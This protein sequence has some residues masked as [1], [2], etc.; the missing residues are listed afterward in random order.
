MKKLLSIV[1]TLALM[2]SL[3]ACLGGCKKEQKPLRILLDYQSWGDDDTYQMNWDF[4]AFRRELIEAGGPADIELEIVPKVSNGSNAERESKLTRIRTE[5]MAGQGPD[6]F[7]MGYQSDW[8]SNNRSLFLMPEKS[9]ELGLFYP[10]DGFLENAQYMHYDEMIPEIVSAGRSEEYGQVVLP[11]EYTFRTT[12]FM[13]DDVPEPLEPCTWQEQA[14]S[15]LT[16]YKAAATQLSAYSYMQFTGSLGKIADYKN[17]KMIMTEEEL[18]EHITQFIELRKEY[19]RGNLTD[20]PPCYQT[21]MKPY[22]E[23]DNLNVQQSSAEAIPYTQHIPDLIPGFYQW[24]EEDEFTMVPMYNTEGGVSATI[25]SWAAIN[26]NCKR[27][28]EAFFVLDY[29]FGK[30]Y[31]SKDPTPFGSFST[32]TSFGVPVYQ[33]MMRKENPVMTIYASD[34]HWRMNDANFAEF[35]R[36]RDQINCVGFYDTLDDELSL[37]YLDLQDIIIHFKNGNV[38][39]VVHEYYT[40]MK[41]ELSE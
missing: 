26:A 21:D 16:A 31:E 4:N 7:I 29:L 3:A 19:V 2:V 6:I 35:E 36:V 13:K 17:R 5:I 23:M 25:H 12:F 33:D 24:A 22:F 11:L 14:Q 20:L 40:R 27:G 8:E 15:K 18:L 32:L 34:Y 1:L 37:L 39:D 9:M 28:D 38:E 41:R 30:Y 10:L